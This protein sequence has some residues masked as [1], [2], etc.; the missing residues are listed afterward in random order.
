VAIRTTYQR[1]VELAAHDDDMY[2]GMIKYI[3]YETEWFPDGNLFYPVMHKRRAF[4]HEQEIRLLKFLYQHVPL[5]SPHGPLGF[6][7][8]VALDALVEEIFVSPYAENW[9]AETVR[10]VVERFAPTLV[11]KLR[12]SKMKS[13]PL[14]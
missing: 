14:Y 4:A 2:L 5:N 10:A 9:Y 7:I 3:D 12:W 13:A 1:L 11:P 6:A 8:P